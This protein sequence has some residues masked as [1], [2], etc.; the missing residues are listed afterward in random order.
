MTPRQGEAK[1]PAHPHPS[2]FVQAPT[3]L[4]F[5]FWMHSVFFSTGAS[6]E[7][8]GQGGGTSATSWV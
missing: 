8:W 7:I 3:R 4:F 5:P 1:G 2:G 6:Q